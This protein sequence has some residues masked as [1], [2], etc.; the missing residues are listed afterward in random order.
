MLTAL[1]IL[2]DPRGSVSAFLSRWGVF[3][4]VYNESV[5]FMDYLRAPEDLGDGWGRILG[6]P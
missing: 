2:T 6:A 4:E 5:F 1:S 3:I